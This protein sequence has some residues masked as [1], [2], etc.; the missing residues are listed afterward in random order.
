MCMLNTLCVKVII[1]GRQYHRL[2]KLASWAKGWLMNHLQPWLQGHN[3]M[4]ISLDRA[5][6]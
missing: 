2:S 5:N 6:I 3:V 1:K 4:E